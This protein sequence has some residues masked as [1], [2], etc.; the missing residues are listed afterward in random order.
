MNGVAPVDLES[1][2]RIMAR[3]VIDVRIVRNGVVGT[4]DMPRRPRLHVRLQVYK[5]RLSRQPW[6]GRF[7]KRDGEGSDPAPGLVRDRCPNAFD[8]SARRKIGRKRVE[9]IHAQMIVTFA[10]RPQVA[11]G[12]IRPQP[13][14]WQLRQTPNLVINVNREAIA[15]GCTPAKRIVRRTE[16][17]VSEPE[18]REGAGRRTND[19][20]L[21]LPVVRVDFECGPDAQSPSRRRGLH[22]WMN[23]ASREHSTRTS[24]RSFPPGI[25]RRR[26]RWWTDDVTAC[27]R[28][29]G[30][31]VVDR[32]PLGV[33]TRAVR[34]TQSTNE[35]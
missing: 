21:P 32:K 10:E 26:G 3:A 8:A 15:C 22:R 17:D 28:D 25:W 20:V 30:P 4:L 19:L 27:I 34:A 7:G 13:V 23:R 1:L 31:V 6:R 35:P 5:V 16:R 24:D 11:E 9:E 18:S 2:K 33:R 29:L 14:E 12:A